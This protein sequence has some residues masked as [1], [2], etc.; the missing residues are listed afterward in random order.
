[1]IET[2]CTGGAPPTCCQPPMTEA[3]IAARNE[4]ID[5]LMA[6]IRARM[7]RRCPS[8]SSDAICPLF[9]RGVD[10]WGCSVCGAVMS[11]RGD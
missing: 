2:K 3:E 10:V 6:E 5:A 9:W 4:R 8:C 11:G 7:P 1:M